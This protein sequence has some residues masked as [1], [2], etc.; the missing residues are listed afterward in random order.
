MS[1]AVGEECRKRRADW[2]DDAC[3]DADD[4]D[5]G[6]G[7]WLASLARRYDAVLVVLLAFVACVVNALLQH[8]TRDVD[9]AADAML[10][11]L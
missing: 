7:C 1:K 5:G 10:Q 3:K 4:D 9:G 2:N 6:G 8:A 11:L